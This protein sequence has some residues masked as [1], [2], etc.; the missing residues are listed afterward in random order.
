MGVS[1]KLS[2]RQI[3]DVSVADVAGRV[4]LSTGSLALGNTLRD[5]ASKG[6]KKILVSRAKVSYVDS[7][8]IGELVS[9]LTT[10]A[11]QGG[12]LK[13]LGL[14]DRVKRLL[15]LTKHYTVFNVHDDEATA[16]SSFS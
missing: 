2:T 16:I 10:V 12:Q 6:H 9:G 13:L 5:L 3:A 4:T 14:T 1:F 8:A 15:Q 7:S 11:T